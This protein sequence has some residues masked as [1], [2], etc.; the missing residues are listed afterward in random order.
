MS[1]IVKPQRFKTGRGACSLIAATQRGRVK[2]TAQAVDEH[3]VI[4]AG[5]VSPVTQPSERGF[6]LI[7]DRYVPRTA[8]LRRRQFD[9]AR[10]GTPD[11]QLASDGVD[12]APLQRDQLPASQPSKCGNPDQLTI[13][14]I[15]GGASSDLLRAD[16]D[17]M[18]DRGARP[19][20]SRTP[21]P[22]PAR[23]S[24]NPASP[25]RVQ[26]DGRHALPGSPQARTCWAASRG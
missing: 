15:V 18:F 25:S 11:G 10:H 17:P 21:A 9:R 13:L 2:A 12:V 14:G 1:Q 19:R 24:R 20:R 23:V 22:R 16:R 6:G 8:R 5:E 4:G 3:I 26:S 7:G